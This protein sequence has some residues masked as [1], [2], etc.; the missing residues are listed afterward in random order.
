MVWRAS[1]AALGLAVVFGACGSGAGSGG[2]GGSSGGGNPDAG[3]HPGTCTEI[4]PQ[5]LGIVGVDDSTG[6]SVLDI[7]VDATGPIFLFQQIAGG[8]ANQMIAHG[9]SRLGGTPTTVYANGDTIP[10]GDGLYIDSGGHG[11]ALVGTSS[12]SYSHCAGGVEMPTGL[13]TI[14]LTNDVFN[15]SRIVSAVQSDGSIMFF[16]YG[17]FAALYGV[18][19]SGGAFSKY[20]FTESSVSYPGAAASAGGFAFACLIGSNSALG[21]A[22]GLDVISRTHD[23]MT[24]RD[25]RMASDGTSLFVVGVTNSVGRYASLQPSIV[26]GATASNLTTV[27]LALDPSTPFDVVFFGGKPGLVQLAAGGTIALS[28]IAA[29]GTLGTPRALVTGTDG[30]SGPVVTGPDGG[31]HLVAS[32]AGH[33]AYV[34]RCPNGT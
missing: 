18:Q 31:L 20:E 10:G 2:G 23:S 26:P 28:S 33:F 13:G 29:D 9:V 34:K 14:A 19:L 32:V 16:T 17:P 4:G 24:Y 3:S 8:V 5:P 6:F 21:V 27:S 12:T 11:C 22:D 15:A 30:L 7:R 25:C 1:L